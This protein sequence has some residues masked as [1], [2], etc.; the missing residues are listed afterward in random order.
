[1][2]RPTASHT[3]SPQ[4]Y[5][6]LIPALTVASLATPANQ[7][8]RAIIAWT[9]KAIPSTQTIQDDF[10]IHDAHLFQGNF[11]HYRNKPQPVRG[12]IHL[13]EERYHL[14]AYEREVEPLDT[15]SGTRTYVMMHPYVFEPNIILTVGL[16]NTP[17]HY[18]DKDEAIGETVSSRADGVRE[19]QIGNA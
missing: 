5:S 16:Y 12:K 13:S 2:L 3:K 10:W 1:M 8:Q 14:E 19:V 18:A 7:R 6:I 9:M 4:S 11:R 17:K 15:L